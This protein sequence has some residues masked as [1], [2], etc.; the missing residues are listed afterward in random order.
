VTE[1]ANIRSL[2]TGGRLLQEIDK[3]MDYR[4]AGSQ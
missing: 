4:V 2:K 1:I 3:R